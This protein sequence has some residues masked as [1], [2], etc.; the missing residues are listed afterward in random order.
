M[1]ERTGSSLLRW[2]AK[3]IFGEEWSQLA[4]VKE[5]PAEIAFQGKEDD[6]AKSHVN[7]ITFNIDRLPY[8]K[9]LLARYEEDESGR[10]EQRQR[11]ARISN[12]FQGLINE[13]T[14][15]FGNEV[16]DMI[17]K[18]ELLHYPDQELLSRIIVAYA[19][20]LFT[21]LRDLRENGWDGENCYIVND[22]QDSYRSD[23]RSRLRALVEG[24]EAGNSEVTLNIPSEYSSQYEIW[25][26]N[27]ISG[28][29]NTGEGPAVL[30]E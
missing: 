8:L 13:L 5:A 16:R 18:Q 28:A 21:K 17:R 26:T 25:F 29:I 27:S 9:T 20:T 6:F 1:K 23:V 15:H 12:I 14:S 11:C 22:W 19:G 30:S 10:V 3:Y 2:I 4:A 7:S 24:L